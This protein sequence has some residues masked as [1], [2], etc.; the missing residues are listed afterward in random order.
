MLHVAQINDRVIKHDSVSNKINI[1][2]YV[3]SMYNNEKRNN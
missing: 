2:T 3:Q 1:G